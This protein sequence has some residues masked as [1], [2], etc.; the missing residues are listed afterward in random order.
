MISSA[1]LFP[2]TAAMRFLTCPHKK[3]VRRGRCLVLVASMTTLLLLTTVFVSRELG[4]TAAIRRTNLKV[5]LKAKYRVFARSLSF[6]AWERK[7]K[8]SRSRKQFEFNESG[9]HVHVISLA[10]SLNRRRTCI[11][12]LRAQNVSYEVF[13]AVDALSGD[14]YR[15]EIQRY[16]GVKKQ[17]SLRRSSTLSRTELIE[18]HERYKTNSLPENFRHDLH[19]RLRFGCTM[20]HVRLW[21]KLLS[22]KEK[23]FVIVED[24]AEISPNF[25]EEMINALRHLP[26]DWDL[27]YAFACDIRP[28]GFLSETIRQFRGGACTLGYAISRKGAEYLIFKA[29]IGSDLPVD[30]MMHLPVSRGR[31]L[32]FY[33]DPFLVRRI[34]EAHAQTTLAYL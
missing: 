3:L 19:E 24:D 2:E 33:A 22:S 28:G 23:F 7:L 25:Q 30:K 26:E 34:N 21:M 18:V 9:L 14:L 12:A 5:L 20:S 6:V 27:F 16:A 32:A 8:E 11:G 15:G 31:M 10:R 1:A 17:K 29:S 13:E 4:E